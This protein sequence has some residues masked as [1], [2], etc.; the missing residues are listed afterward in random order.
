MDL[1]YLQAIIQSNIGK[2]ETKYHIT[3]K[4]EQETQKYSEG[5]DNSAVKM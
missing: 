1:L 2:N 4:K 5:K 3:I